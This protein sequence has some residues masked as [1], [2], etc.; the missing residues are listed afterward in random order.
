MKTSNFL[1]LV[2][3]LLGLKTAAVHAQ[4]SYTTNADNTITLT[5]YTGSGDVLTITNM[6]TG[7]PVTGTSPQAFAGTT[8][9]SIIIPSSITNFGN[10]PFINSSRLTNLTVDAQ[11]VAYSSV[12]GVLFNKNQT[13][14]IEYPG[15]RSGS[16][17][18]PPTVST[19]WNAAFYACPH[20]TGITFPSSVT[21][22]GQQAF[23]SCPNL[24]S[25]TLPSNLTNIARYVFANCSGL[26]NIT[27]DSAN[28]AFS[29]VDGVLFNTDQ[30]AILQYPGGKAGSYSMPPTVTSVGNAAFM[31][32][33]SLTN[34]VFSSSVTNLGTQAFSDC[35][36]LTSLTLSSSI[37][38]IGSDAF[39]SCTNLTSV[40]IPDRVTSIGSSAFEDCESLTN[41]T[42]SAS[43]TNVGDRAFFYCPRLTGAY[44]QGNAPNGS[45]LVFGGDTNATIYHLVG[46]TGWGTMFGGRTIALYANLIVTANPLSGG[47]VSGSGAYPFGTNVQITATAKSGWT[48]AGWSDGNLQT[49]RTITI[50]ADG[51]IV[52]A[53]FMSATGG[54]ITSPMFSGP[55]NGLYDLTHALTNLSAAFNGGVL[56]NGQTNVV[57]ITERLSVVQ[58]ITG[59]TIATGTVTTV[60]VIPSDSGSFTFPATYK[61]KG[62]IKS[63]GSNLLL[64][65]AFTGKGSTMSNAVTTK[66]SESVTLLITA[67]H[68]GIMTGRQTGK[69][70]QSGRDGG[71]SKILNPTFGPEPFMFAPLGWHLSMTLT[72]TTTKVTGHA[73]VNLA[74]GRI[75]P[76]TVTGTTKSGTSKLILTGTSTGGSD[77]AKGGKLTVTMTGTHLGGISGSLLGQKVNLSGL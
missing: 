38:S 46:A 40:L 41:V 63:A 58:S 60:T 2:V 77:T 69:A 72:S 18:V 15:G 32:C 34:I 73:T 12:D 64:S 50:T 42:I 19:I 8:F 6:I 30:T 57:N 66:Y 71:T 9:A 65:L 3:L 21:S 75:F 74:N 4:Y 17:I 35:T 53:N 33:H 22:I 7:L 20:L 25:I 26:T 67:D 29:S 10:Y 62:S 44:F 37:I 55:T 23:Q 52:A 47:T 5:G 14:L 49:P 54:S 31:D 51:L 39:Y 48:F 28:P 1:R 16:Y 45:S 59:A 61:L 76:F 36:G 13:T 70:S 43:V 27:V 68:N 56:T 11:N 24:T